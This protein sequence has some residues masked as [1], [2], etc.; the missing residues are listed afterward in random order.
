MSD[1]QFDLTRLHGSR[2]VSVARLAFGRPDTDFLCFGESDQPSPAAALTAL[3]ASL[4]RGETLYPDV[5]GLPPLR[6]AIADYLS[7]LHQ[8]PVT[9]DRV[10]VT[11]SGM[12]ALAITLSAVVRAGDRVVLHEPAWP[13]AGNAARLRG[14]DVVALPLDARQDGRFH[15]DLG[16]LDAA[17]AGARCFILNSPN[18]PTGWTATHEE[19]RDILA[20]CRR[21]GCWLISDEVYSRLVYDG[22]EA[23]PSILDI[24]EPDDRIIVC[25]SFSK[26]WVMTGWRLGWLIAPQGTRDELAELVEVTHSGVAPF[27]QQA[28]LAAVADHATPATFR[29]HCTEGRAIAAQLLGDLPGVRYASPDGAFYAFLQ[30]EGVSDSLTLAQTLVTGHGIAVAPGIAFGESGEGWLRVC[31]AVAPDR[32][33]RALGRLAEGLVARRA[34][35]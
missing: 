13:N 16:K 30:V 19:L 15:L 1:S 29:A 4:G 11:A 3:A 26:T 14:A 33:T 5:R 23:A 20:L 32:L 21:H 34:A 25:N 6:H 17:L 8:R 9:E 27:I 10:I 22:S 18:N 28:G 35:A 12:A 2:I 24:A 7:G 31:Y